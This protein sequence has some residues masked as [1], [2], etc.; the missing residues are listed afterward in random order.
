[1]VYGYG[2]YGGYGDCGCGGSWELDA[3][4]ISLTHPSN[5]TA[6]LKRE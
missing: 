4:S 3:D 6:V 5:P 2:G 1:M